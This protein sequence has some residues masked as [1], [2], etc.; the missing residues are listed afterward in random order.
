MQTTLFLIG[1]VA[2]TIALLLV[3]VFVL[4]SSDGK[5]KIDYR[6]LFILGV[7]WI[8]I[9]LAIGNHIVWIIGLAL[10]TIGLMKKDKWEKQKPLSEL[11]TSE[12]KLRVA[13]LIGLS[14][15]LIAG[16]IFYFLNR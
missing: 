16:V 9:G 3:S 6:T 14:L 1:G 4:K 13:L 15:F 7:V 12:R 5:R 8:P 2:V 11:D 10:L